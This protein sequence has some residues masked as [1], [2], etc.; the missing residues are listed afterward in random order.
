MKNQLAMWYT[1]LVGIGFL[2]VF[3]TLI[4]DYAEFGF[5]IETLHKIFHVALGGIVVSFAWKDPAW[6]TPFS[7]ANGLFFSFV[8]LAGWLFPNFGTPDLEALGRE[9]TILHAA[10]GL[11][12]IVSGFLNRKISH[13]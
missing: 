3:I 6:W 11:G 8:A 1:R 13:V 4:T 7:L 9:D 12:G 2:L 10:V 5:R